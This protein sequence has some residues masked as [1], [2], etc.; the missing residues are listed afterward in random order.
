MNEELEDITVEKG[1]EIVNNSS[2]INS[3]PFYK[4][5]SFYIWIFLIM[6]IIIF[7]LNFC[8]TIVSG[9]SMN[10]TLQN[11]Q[12]L[13]ASRH[14]DDLERFDI[15]LIKADVPII[16]RVIGM[17]NDII[18]YENDQLY[19]NGEIVD[20]KY[21]TGF[22]ED[23]FIQL[24]ENEYFCLGDNRE[25]SLDSRYYGAFKSDDIFAKIIKKGGK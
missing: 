15:V 25:N 17:P 18:I 8:I 22:T 12:V 21:G 24:G 10:P 5:V 3:K 9:A 23:L 7:N 1:E 2:P 4:K 16:K 19:V 11:G 13:L 14:T 6:G 20:D